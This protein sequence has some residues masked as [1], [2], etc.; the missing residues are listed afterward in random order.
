MTHYILTEDGAISGLHEDIAEIIQDYDPELF[1]AWIP[2]AA[3]KPNDVNPWAVI[4]RPEGKP[5]YVVRTF[6]ECD[7]RILAYLWTNDTQ[8]TNVLANL[9]AEE[10]A[11][12]A[13]QM[14]QYMDAQEEN[15]EMAVSILKSPKSRY[16][17][18]VNG[19]KVTF[20]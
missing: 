16:T 12:R 3:R 14:K 19:K 9:E 10:N 5:E 15:N 2:P 4:H 6:E 7:H 20:E 17:A 13:I 8:R 1:L 18:K 11:I